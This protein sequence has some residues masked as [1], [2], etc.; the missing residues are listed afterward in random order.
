MLARVPLHQEGAPKKPTDVATAIVEALP[1]SSMIAER[2]TLAGPGFIN[3][4]LSHGWISERIHSMLLQAKQPPNGH[5][6]RISLAFCAYCGQSKHPC[7]ICPS[8]I[9]GLLRAND[10][11]GD[12]SGQAAPSHHSMHT[13]IYR[14]GR[15]SCRALARGR[16]PSSTRGRWWTSPPRTWP[17]RCMLAICGRPSSGTPSPAAWSSAA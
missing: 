1:A 14:T 3:V 8:F 16:R 12:E 4:K 9:S 7:Q 17:R 10:M 6:L 13:I 11:N 15:W 5:T 2:P